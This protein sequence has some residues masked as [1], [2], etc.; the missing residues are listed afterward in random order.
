M[1]TPTRKSMR[2]VLTDETTIQAAFLDAHREAIR[3]H[4]M[5]NLPM[6]VWRD[7]AVVWIP[8][9]QLPDVDGPSS[10]GADT[11]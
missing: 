11:S 6:V 3:Q 9:D 7:G 2:S 8:P 1:T 10:D 5:A 4:R